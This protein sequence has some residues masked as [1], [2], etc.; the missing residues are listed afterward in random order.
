MLEEW[1]E[2]NHLGRGDEEQKQ[3]RKTKQIKISTQQVAP[4][5]KVIVQT[6]QWPA[7]K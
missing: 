3:K 5:R 6:S 7:N 2:Q 1:A 4:R